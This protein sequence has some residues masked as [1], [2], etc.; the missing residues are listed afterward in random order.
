MCHLVLD[1][2]REP[3]PRLQDVRGSDRVVVGA[4]PSGLAAAIVLAGA[5]QHVRVLERRPD[6]GW[7]FSGDFQ[8]LENW[9]SP[10]DVLARLGDLGIHAEFD[11]QP[12]REVTFYDSHLRPAVLRSREPLF[13]LVR[14]GP[15]AGSLDRAL[16]EQAQAAGVDVRFGERMYRAEPRWIV[17]TGPQTGET[18]ILLAQVPSEPAATLLRGRRTAFWQEVRQWTAPR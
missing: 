17:A 11:H 3:S 6:V 4:G 16:L 8:R 1:K 14:R 18:T 15:T 9:T 7:R 5:G 13:C 2:S 10:R 12:V